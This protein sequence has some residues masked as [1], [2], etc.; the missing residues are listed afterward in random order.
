[1]LAKEIE[2]I[3]LTIA[4]PQDAELMECSAENY[5][6]NLNS[7]RF[8]E[9][10]TVIEEKYSIRFKTDDLIK[11]ADGSVDDFVRMIERYATT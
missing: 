7:L 10:I 4:Q 5:L 8:I 6:K 1:M 3:I 11:L 9:L 2:Q